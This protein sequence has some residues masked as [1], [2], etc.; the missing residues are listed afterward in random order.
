MSVA[1]E[2]L[3]QRYEKAAAG[4]HE[5]INFNPVHDRVLLIGD[6]QIS[7]NQETV[8]LTSS[9]EHQDERRSKGI[10]DVHHM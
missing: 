10:R 9:A 5:F 6:E 4:H 7:G 2:G 1:S 3:Y 8:T